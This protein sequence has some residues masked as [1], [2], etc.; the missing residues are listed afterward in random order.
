MAKLLPCFFDENVTLTFGEFSGNPE[1]PDLLRLR[2]LLP[3]HVGVALI[4]K[5]LK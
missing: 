2:L 1:R 5:P 4:S 3:Q